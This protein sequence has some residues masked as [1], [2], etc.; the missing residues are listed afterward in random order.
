MDWLF[1]HEK[2]ICHVRVAG[3]VLKDHKIL[4]QKEVGGGEYALP[5]GHLKFGETTEEALVR[6]YREEIGAEI[7]CKRLLWIEENFWRWND[8]DA[9]NI[10]FYYLAEFCEEDAVPDGFTPQGD[11]EE[12][13]FGW[14][15][16]EEVPKI[17]VYPQFLK[18]EIQNLA[19]YPKHFVRREV[20]ADGEI[21]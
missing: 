21:L 20:A 16:V 7:A 15:P 1:T 19:D 8:R 13:V 9:H 12:V 3:V 2:G 11:N 5:G 14:I 17:T 10:C 18:E 6:E 4:V